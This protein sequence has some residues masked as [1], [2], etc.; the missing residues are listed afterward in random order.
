VNV[1]TLDELMALATESHSP[2]ISI[3]TPMERLGVETQQNSIRFK[4]LVQQVEEQL[5]TL[6]LRKQDASDLLQTLHQMDTYDF[7]QHQSEGLAIFLSS[8]QFRYYRLPIAFSELT[9]V[10]DRFH[11]KP[12]LQ[13]LSG[14]GHFYTLALSQNQVRLF[15]GT[16]HSISEV[17]LTDV[18]TSIAEALQYDDPEKSL[19]FHTGTSQSGGGDRSAMFHGQ[20][21]GNDDH[22]DNLLRY[23]QKVSDGIDLLLKKEQAPFILAG[24]DY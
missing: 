23:F 14:D 4:N 1:L 10:T 17:E 11:L 3:Y 19:Q 5:L 15:Q 13:L 20:G 2:C 12:L 7:W 18:P 24:V 22:K 16:R 8:G 21:A 6:G 9:V